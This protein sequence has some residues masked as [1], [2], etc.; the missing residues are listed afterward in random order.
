MGRQ[1]SAKL[2]VSTKHS[3]AAVSAPNVYTNDCL[4]MGG[5]SETLH[6]AHPP[7]QAQTLHIQP[8]TQQS[9]VTHKTQS[10]NSPFPATVKCM[11][12]TKWSQHYFWTRAI[13]PHI[14][15]VHYVRYGMSKSFPSLTIFVQCFYCFVQYFNV[16]CH[17]CKSVFSFFYK[18]TRHLESAQEFHH[19]LTAWFM[20]KWQINSWFQT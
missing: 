19:V 1:V 18:L 11:A 3:T 12:K 16:F 8:K 14:L 15:T 20:C 6:P 17:F 5:L 7:A 9:A 2:T 10:F 13:T 4:Y